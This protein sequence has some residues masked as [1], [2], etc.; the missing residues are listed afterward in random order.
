MFK[1]TVSDKSG[2]Q[3]R[4]D[5]NKPEIS[6]GRMKG[7]DIVLPKGNVSKR[8]ATIYLR[9]KSFYVNDHGSTNGTYIN[10]RK[11][12]SEQLVAEGEKIY[13]G[14][15]ILQLDALSSS[16]HN[17]YV[18]PPRHTLPPQPPGGQLD[19]RAPQN[20]VFDIGDEL[21]RDPLRDTYTTMPPDA[22]SNRSGGYPHV[23][24]GIRDTI[25][26]HDD[27]QQ[28]GPAPGAKY[29]AVPYSASTSAPP[30]SMPVQPTQPTPTPTPTPAPIAS[31]A[32]APPK[33]PVREPL[34]RATPYP[35]SRGAAMP[36]P[37]TATP[38]IMSNDSSS[39][40]LPQ[41][42][43]LNMAPPEISH[44]LDA[45]LFEKQSDLFKLVVEKF[46]AQQW[47]KT[48]PVEN[49]DKQRFQRELD[50][51]I[52][53]LKLTEDVDELKELLTQEFEGL[54]IIDTLLAD[55]DIRDIYINS[56]DQILVREE[57]A[58]KQYKHAFS[59][60][61]ALIAIGHRLLA[62]QSSD[63]KKLTA[64]IRRDDGVRI[65]VIMPPLTA[66]NPALTIRKPPTK[67]PSIM[68]L[69]EQNVLSPGMA[70]FLMNAIDAGR[71]I[72][73]AGPTSSGKTTLI[74]ALAQLIH[75]GIR[76]V[77][78]EDYSHLQLEQGSAVK[79]EVNDSEGYDKRFLL[80][81][82]LSMHPQRIILDECRSAE[83]YDWVTSVASGTEGSMLTVHGVNALD[84]LGR[85]ESLCL[86]GSRDI[87]PRGMREQIARSINIV[88]T[89]NRTNEGSVRVQQI[90]ELQGVD[91]DAFRLNDIFYFRTMG[92]AGSFHPT[93]YIPLFYEDLK[94]VMPDIDFS[95]F[96]E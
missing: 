29:D 76:I 55:A 40:G 88:V 93:G 91:L 17:D 48:L 45:E 42:V 7:N 20:T 46:P 65:H 39:D 79:L 87:S 57:G 36:T 9:D 96:Q 10:G 83:A 80:Q 14:D 86:L 16:G 94:Q 37:A 2:H 74:N 49:K 23:P 89:V 31:K 22:D 27:L 61:D 11:V 38:P 54:G 75:D 66:K 90:A 4:L 8:H 85:L 63:D 56:H 47:P 51:A 70:D 34:K 5:F 72:A 77:C 67:T 41:Q 30:A 64:D 19:E 26:A 44:D 84:A 33:P 78:I 59:H 58:L 92:T 15:F 53:K 32:P 28:V 24:D 82:A 6:I 1:V 13:I 50:A 43:Q 12:L 81:Q 69:V 62:E 18:A 60:P 52:S 68:D 73:V 71:S 25:G 3:S 95:V 21:P 35:P